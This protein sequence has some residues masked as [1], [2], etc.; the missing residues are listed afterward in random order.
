M[1]KEE[2][3]E[4]LR[5]YRKRSPWKIIG[6]I[7]VFVAF[8]G[9]VAAVIYGPA[10]L[11][12]MKGGA[13]EHAQAKAAFRTVVAAA[14]S[15][16]KANDSVYEGITAAKIKGQTGKVIV[17]DGY[18]KAGQVGISDYNSKRLV[19]MYLGKSGQEYVANIEAGNIEFNF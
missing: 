19:L 10:L 4:L 14:E 16:R 9:I 6:L 18:P 3:Q 13:A 2:D 1:T 12:N 11:N 5:K 17:V 15:Y 8:V 7:L